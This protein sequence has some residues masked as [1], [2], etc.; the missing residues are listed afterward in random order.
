MLLQQAV[1]SMLLSHGW[2]M[3]TST[4]PRAQEGAGQF[5]CILEVDHGERGKDIQSCTGNFRRTN[6]V[7]VP[8]FLSSLEAAT[9]LQSNKAMY[10]KLEEAESADLCTAI[11]WSPDNIS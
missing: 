10:L 11:F 4:L 8:A 9:V 7:N 2:T 3:D 6:N 1:H 5:L